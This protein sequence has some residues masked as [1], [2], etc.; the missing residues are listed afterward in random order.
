MATDT[1]TLDKLIEDVQK[2]QDQPAKPNY[3][4]WLLIVIL[5]IIVGTYIWGIVRAIQ[6]PTI[7]GVEISNARVIGSTALCAGNMLVIAYDLRADGTGKL[8]EDATV[9]VEVPE[10]KTVIYSV[11]RPLLVDGLVDQQEVIAWLIPENYINPANL[12]ETPL[13]P[14][15]YTRIF[16]IGSPSD[17]DDF[18][19]DRVNFSVKADKDCPP[20]ISWRTLYG[21]Q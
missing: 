16:S 11:T 8:E 7:R 17:D 21:G 1:K 20:M 13:P 19:L 3:T 5:A 6:T 15:L 14:G 10:P 12:K 4:L 18:D 9:W 2:K